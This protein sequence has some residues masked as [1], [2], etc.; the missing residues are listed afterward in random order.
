MLSFP[1]SEEVE[2]EGEILE[3]STERGYFKLD[4][5]K[6]GEFIENWNSFPYSGE[7]DP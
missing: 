6:E 3:E 5:K 4:K 2:A 7:W 1:F